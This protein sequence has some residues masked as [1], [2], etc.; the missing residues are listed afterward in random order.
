MNKLI[1]LCAVLGALLLAS[2]ASARRGATLCVGRAQGCYSTIQAAVDAAHNG[3]TI[4]VERG[5]F[6]GGVTIDKSVSLLGAGARG[7]IISGGGPVLTIG[8]FLAVR[9]ERL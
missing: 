4:R 3:D 1:V 9:P 2:Q 6:D 5:T 7:T 8:A